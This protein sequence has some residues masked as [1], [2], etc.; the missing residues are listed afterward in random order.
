MVTDLLRVTNEVF[1]NGDIVSMTLQTVMDITVATDTT[2][3]R[4]PNVCLHMLVFQ[5]HP[6]ISLILIPL[7]VTNL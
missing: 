2:D 1:D 5:G 6:W 4:I 3:H 7:I